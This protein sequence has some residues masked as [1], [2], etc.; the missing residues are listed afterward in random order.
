[1]V[2][3]GVS[4]KVGT[5]TSGWEHFAE[6]KRIESETEPVTTEIRTAILGMCNKTRLLDLVENFVLFDTSKG[7]TIK[8][9]AKY[10]QYYGVNLAVEGVLNRDKNHGKLGTYWHTTGS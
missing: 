9:L 1:M 6:W 7:R 4:T 10:H 5:I 8:L 3:N 2:S